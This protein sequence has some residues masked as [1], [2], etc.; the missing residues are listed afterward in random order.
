M[1]VNQVRGKLPSC[2]FDSGI[3]LPETLYFALFIRSADFEKDVERN[4]SFG[5]ITCSRLEEKGSKEV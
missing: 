3:L 4:V 2:V 1:M 5:M